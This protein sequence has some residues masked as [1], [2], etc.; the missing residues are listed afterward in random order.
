MFRVTLHSDREGDSQKDFADKMWGKAL[1]Y[2]MTNLITHG[3]E[4]VHND[5]LTI[6]IE[7][8]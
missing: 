2:I 6:T 5:K 1:G 8:I 4:C 7:W 3:E